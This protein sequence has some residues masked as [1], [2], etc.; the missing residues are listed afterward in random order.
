VPG[1]CRG[2]SIVCEFQQRDDSVGERL[3]ARVEDRDPELLG[4]DGVGEEPVEG[5]VVGGGIGG[6][7]PR[8]R[9]SIDP[10]VQPEHARAIEFRSV[11]VLIG[12]H[13]RRE[14]RP[15]LVGVEREEPGVHCF[16]DVG[17]GI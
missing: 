1:L 12:R 17:L 4:I 6:G 15:V 13:E 7:D 10:D 14:V 3:V 5:G 8:E 11:V 9:P 16:D 2:K